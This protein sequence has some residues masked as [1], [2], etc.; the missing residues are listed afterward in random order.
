MTHDK[1]PEALQDM[2]R[3]A[4]GEKDSNGCVGPTWAT[5]T[6][7]LSL[8]DEIERLRAELI[9]ESARTAEEKLRAD[10]MT[11]Q[12]AMQAKMH[13]EAARKLAALQSTKEQL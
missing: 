6:E 3:R 10:H 9:K 5:P 8:I 7:V 1:M 12:H 13:A 4:M 2:K 11:K